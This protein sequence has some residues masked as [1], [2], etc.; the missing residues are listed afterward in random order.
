MDAPHKVTRLLHAWGQGDEDALARL[1]P[2]VEAEID[3][4]ARIYMAGERAGNSLQATALVN[5]AYIRLVDAQRVR[6]Q[7][8]VH[9][10]AMAARTMRR[11]LVDHARAK[12]YQ[13]RG[14]DA[15]R[16]TF[17]ERLLPGGQRERRT[18]WRST[19]RSPLSSTPMPA[20]AKWWSWSLRR[21]QRRG[22]RS[23]A[24]CVRRHRQWRDWKFCERH[25]CFA[26]FG[27][28]RYA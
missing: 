20:R 12:G 21:A 8:R 16:V 14:G 18:S 23:G 6:W 13:K 25:G 22:D 15:V 24:R 5:E 7:D 17:D 2:L 26:N 4:I 27:R 1:L 10:V 9:F 3:R 11:V 28:R 19:T